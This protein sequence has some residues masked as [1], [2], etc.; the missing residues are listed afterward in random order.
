MPSATDVSA[1]LRALQE[2]VSSLRSKTASVVDGLEKERKLRESD[3]HQLHDR[4]SQERVADMTTNAQSQVEFENRTKTWVE[5]FV[6]GGLAMSER[7]N[8]LPPSQLLTSS[9]SPTSPVSF[10]EQR[11]QDL[12]AKAKAWAISVKQDCMALDDRIRSLDASHTA[13]LRTLDNEMGC[14]KRSL[15]GDI[16]AWGPS[17]EAVLKNNALQATEAS[18]GRFRGVMSPSPASAVPPE[19]SPAPVIAIDQSPW[20]DA[21]K[22]AVARQLV[23]LEVGL[24][25][26]ERQQAAD[27]ERAVNLMA[28]F[29]QELARKLD[30]EDQ[31][32]KPGTFASFRER[33]ENSISALQQDIQVAHRGMMEVQV[34]QP[35][36]L[37]IRRRVEA[38]ETV[39]P[40]RADAQEVSKMQLGLSE[41]STKVHEHASQLRVLCATVAEHDTWY[42]QAQDHSVSLRTLDGKA[43]DHTSKLLSI[44]ARAAALESEMRTKADA[45]QHYTKDFTADLIKDLIK[46]FYRRDEIDTMFSKVW[47]RTPDVAAPLTPGSGKNR[48]IALPAIQPLSK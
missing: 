47:W 14:L 2:E 41:A 44:E 40:S 36:L 16:A 33:T 18:S 22:A 37:A 35:D 34:N 24:M 28:S 32:D 30:K 20:N 9:G 46:D 15:A 13:D 17:I 45:S 6:K 7:V 19:V 4:L 31:L 21:E 3:V 23:T 29:E 39:F 26:A 38:L 43:H 12:E 10:L 5:A 42:R 27:R 1:Q 11:L 48:R 8:Q 25:Q